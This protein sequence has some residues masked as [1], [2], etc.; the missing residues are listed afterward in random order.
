M[1]RAGFMPLRT[2]ALLLAAS[3]LG[4]LS[5]TELPPRLETIPAPAPINAPFYAIVSL[6][7]PPSS[8][9]FDW[10]PDAQINGGTITASFDSG[11]GILCPGGGEGAYTGFPLPLPPLA[12]GQYTLKVVDAGQPDYIWATLPLTIEPGKAP[13]LVL[14]SSPAPANKPFA[15]EFSILSHPDNL[16]VDPPVANVNGNT[17]AFGFDDYSYCASTCSNESVYRSYPVQFPALAPG[18]YDVEFVAYY[19]KPVFPP[20]PQMPPVA[21]F[22]ITVGAATSSVPTARIPALLV[23]VLS[24]IALARLALPRRQSRVLS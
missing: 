6:P 24:L 4:A 19:I 23:M 9:G 16:G 18:Q 13:A 8:L 17:I 21:R 14:N 20:H 10:A 3:P 11:C 15:A 1:K 2:L 7:A 12:A 22:S 5:Q